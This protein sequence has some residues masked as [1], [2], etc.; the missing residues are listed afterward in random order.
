MVVRVSVAATE[1]SE[2]AYRPADMLPDMS[3]SACNG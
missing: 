3:Q 1:D 2:E